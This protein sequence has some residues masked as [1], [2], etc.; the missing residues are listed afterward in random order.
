MGSVKNI[1]A[2]IRN[3]LDSVNPVESINSLTE[4][5]EVIKEVQEV[6][7]NPKKMDFQRE[8]DN[9]RMLNP[10]KVDRVTLP[11][12]K[13]PLSRPVTLNKET[14]YDQGDSGTCLVWALVNSL[15]SLGFKIDAQ[16]LIAMLGVAINGGV[17]KIETFNAK[18]L[19]KE[20]SDNLTEDHE[21][22]SLSRVQ[23]DSS[24]Y[25]EEIQANG[26]Q[27]KNVIDAKGSLFMGVHTALL[28]KDDPDYDI[29]GPHAISV[30]GY[31]IGR[32]NQMDVHIIDSNLGSMWVPLETLSNS[33]LTKQ[34]VFYRE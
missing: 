1:N 29:G 17:K 15:T 7:D 33:I 12:T 30:V 28:Y 26:Q 14:F 5:Q 18:S 25:K 11:D 9:T 34:R 19:I 3:N 32:G 21:F 13:F 16:S 2:L 24:N 10:L 27:I 23:E 8:I 20:D 22:H 31:R 4:N 6:L